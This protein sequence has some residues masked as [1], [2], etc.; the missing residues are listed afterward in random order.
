MYDG[1]FSA[2]KI[3]KSCHCDNMDGPWGHYVKWDKSV[4]DKYCTILPI[5]GNFKNKN[6]FVENRLVVARF[7]A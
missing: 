5:C 7:K 4:K 6:E 2:I 1:I 3:M